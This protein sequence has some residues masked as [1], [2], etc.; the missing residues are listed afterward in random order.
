MKVMTEKHATMS[1]IE[2]QIRVARFDRPNSSTE[3]PNEPRSSMFT[4]DWMSWLSEKRVNVGS[5]EFV[6]KIYIRKD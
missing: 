1:T 2:S 5:K 4:K 6:I 3:L